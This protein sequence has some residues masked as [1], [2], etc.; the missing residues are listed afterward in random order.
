MGEYDPKEIDEKPCP[1]CDG[2]G[3]IGFNGEFCK[4]C[5][6]S[7]VVTEED[8]ANYSFDDMEEVV[9]PHCEGNGRTRLNGEFCIYC[10]GDCLVS[11][12]MADE[13]DADELVKNRVHTA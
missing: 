12:E 4:Y 6:G 9:C 11:K 13:Y 3:T 8:A 10:K 5:G 1:H 2:R 7:Q